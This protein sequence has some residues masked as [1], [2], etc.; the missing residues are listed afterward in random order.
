MK[1]TFLK[2]AI[3]SLV[4]SASGFAGASIISFEFD[5]DDNTISLDWSLLDGSDADSNDAISS[6]FSTEYELTIN[7]VTTSRT[8]TITFY[9]ED[10]GGG[11]V[12]AGDELDISATGVVLFTGSLDAPVFKIGGFTMGDYD[13][14]GQEGILTITKVSTPT[15]NVTTPTTIAII[16]LG[17]L[18]L[19]SRRFK[20]PS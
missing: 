12:F 10:S 20:K 3:F 13:N 16:A 11:F 2:A 4:L 8:I 1:F 7:S 9:D 14:G 18:A 6:A 19:A 15:T 17:I 5:T